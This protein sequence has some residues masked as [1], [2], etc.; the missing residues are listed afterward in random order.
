MEPV[1]NLSGVGCPLSGPD[2]LVSAPVAADDLDTG[3][4]FEPTGQRVG[5]ALGQQIDRT[6]PFQVDQ[7]GALLASASEGE[8]VNANDARR[9]ALGAAV[10]TQACYD[11]GGR[12][13]Q[14]QRA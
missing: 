14:P 7:N 9:C 11:H 4:R 10:R 6:M 5:T 1:G 12:R 3:M 8:V 2:R 13:H